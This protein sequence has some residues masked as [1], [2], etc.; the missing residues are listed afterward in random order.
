MARTVLPGKP[1]PLG[2]KWNG[3]GT[4]FAVYSENATGV[5][6]CLYDDENNQTDVLSLEECTAFVWH[7]F[8]PGIRPGQRYGF[9]VHGPWDPSKGHRFNEHKLL[10]D[11]YAQ[12]IVGDVAVGPVHLP[13]HLRRRES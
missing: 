2:A 12:A 9:R 10:V 5:E 13:L 7:G 8:L 6:L 1:Y 11:P 3:R 4:N